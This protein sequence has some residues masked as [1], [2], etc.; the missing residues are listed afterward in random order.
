MV[1]YDI[2]LYFIVYSIVFRGPGDPMGSHGV[3]WDEK[4]L[5]SGHGV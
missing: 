4:L 1:L 5:G 2:I 3:P